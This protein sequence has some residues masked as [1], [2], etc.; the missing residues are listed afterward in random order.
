MK[1]KILLLALLMVFQLF[2]PGCWDYSEYEALAQVIG[3]GFDFNNESNEVTV[4]V[5]YIPTMKSEKSTSEGNSK[6]SAGIQGIIHSATDKTV[7]GA[8]A[9]LQQVIFKQLFLGYVKVVVFGEEAAKYKI[10][11]I[12]DHLDRAPTIRETAYIVVSQ[13]KAEETLST[14]DASYSLA[15]SQQIFN[16]I[17]LSKNTGATFPI[18]LLNFT[19]MLAISGLEP[20]APRIITTPTKQN[21]SED[22]SSSAA[23]VKSDERHEGDQRLEGIA[24]FKEDK[25]V[26]WLNAKESLGYGWISGKEIT[27]YKTSEVSDEANTEDILY[28]RIRK[29][30]RKIKA[31]IDNGKP[32]ISVDVSVISD[33][34]KY[35]TNK[36]SDFLTPQ[37]I[38][39]MEK[40][41]ANSIR[42]DITASLMKGQKEL[43]SDIYGFGFE[44][45]RKDPKLWQTEYKKKWESTFPNV[46]TNINVDVKIINTG[47][48]IKKLDVK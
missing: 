29:S 31:E 11:D 24:V 21:M 27:A 10:L 17:E 30:S 32:I 14:L 13:G 42:S 18:T 20:T 33:L 1:I 34:R 48:N 40:K 47:T 45:F 19:Q 36:G 15:S 23:N 35:Y 8:F 44:L 5:Q 22:K 37:E 2:L 38:S 9:K 16:L 46:P 6:Y 25:L 12:I 3:I 41:L 39:I 43:K 28:Y 4:T 7:Y 26:G